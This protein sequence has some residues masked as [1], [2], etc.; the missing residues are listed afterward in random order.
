MKGCMILYELIHYVMVMNHIICNQIKNCMI[1][2]IWTEK[3]HRWSV[4]ESIIYDI[5]DQLS[6]IY[7]IDNQL[8]IIYDI[9]DQLSIIYDINNQLSIIYDITKREVV[10]TYMNSY[11]I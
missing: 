7:D 6:I 5:N 11:M 10:W 9:D 1:I 3:C 2:Y 4:F 8:W